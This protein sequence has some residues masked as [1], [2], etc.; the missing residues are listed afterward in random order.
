MFEL[1]RF[2][3]GKILDLGN[4]TDME[5]GLLIEEDVGGS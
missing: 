1:N 5:D 4:R 2:N 3:T